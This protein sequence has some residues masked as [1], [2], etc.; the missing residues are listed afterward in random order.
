MTPI[1]WTTHTPGS[2]KPAHL[3][4]STWVI[5]V[6]DDQSEIVTQAGSLVS[7]GRVRRW[8]LTDERLSRSSPG[9]PMYE[10][11][12]GIWHTHTIPADFTGL[13]N[14]R[15]HGSETVRR[16]LDPGTAVAGGSIA[17]WRPAPNVLP[18]NQ[19]DHKHSGGN[20]TLHTAAPRAI[21]A[22]AANDF[23]TAA[24]FVIHAQDLH[25]PLAEWILGQFKA[26]VSVHELKTIFA[27]LGA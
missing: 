19:M 26:G 16:G 5:T 9:V 20:G 7:W 11:D 2:P 10:P 1:E 17:C 6:M 8:A 23:Y 12:A 25:K 22:T 27:E 13:V 3:G 21:P 14:V 18:Q 15:Y 4:G 24:A